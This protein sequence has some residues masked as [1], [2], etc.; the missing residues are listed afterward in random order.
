MNNF[1]KDLEAILN[2]YNHA[3][4]EARQK[5]VT[6]GAEVLKEALESS[7]PRYTGKLSKSFVINTKY[8]DKRFVGSNRVVKDKSS[9]NVPL[10]NILEF[11]IGGKPFMRETFNRK[12]SEIYNV[13]K[14]SIKLGGQ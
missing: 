12:E 11:K 14:H 6:A 3:S 5:A 10:T 9:N 1:E 7:A 2:E 8:S 4:Y 13:I